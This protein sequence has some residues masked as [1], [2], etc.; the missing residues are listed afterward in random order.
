MSEKT[1][2]ATEPEKKS[3]PSPKKAPAPAKPDPFSPEAVAAHNA[4]LKRQGAKHCP[5][6]AGHGFTRP[7]PRRRVPCELCHGTGSVPVPE[8]E[9]PW[10]CPIPQ[11]PAGDFSPAEYT[12]AEG[13]CPKC[14]FPLRLRKV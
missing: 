13:R 6:C 14:G 8:G 12:A 9:K 11:C 1:P 4:A 5:A 2:P 7:Q 10:F 3:D